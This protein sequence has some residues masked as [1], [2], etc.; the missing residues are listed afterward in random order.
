MFK[1]E[2]VKHKYNIKEM[3][4]ILSKQNGASSSF[5]LKDKERVTFAY[6]FCNF[7]DQRLSLE[8]IFA[9]KNNLMKFTI[10]FIYRATAI[11]D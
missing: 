8:K 10:Q 9:Q 5:I 2:I 1:V 11:A 3:K 4:T 7:V 6:L